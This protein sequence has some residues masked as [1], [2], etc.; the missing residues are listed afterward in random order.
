ML[1]EAEPL[2]RMVEITL[3]AQFVK[4][5]EPTNLLLI[6]KPETGKTTVLSISQKKDFVFYVNEITAKMLV[7][8]VF[9]LVER[10]EVKVVV[11]P[12]LL[13]CLE[14]Q[15]STRQQFLM[16]IKTAIE[17]GFTQ[18]QTYHKRYLAK[19]PI[20]F[21]MI[22]AITVEDFNK[23]KKYLETTGLLS[24]FI[25]FSYDYPIDKVRRILDFIENGSP[26]E[27][28]IEFRV[29]KREAE[30]EGNPELFRR[31]E[32][33]STKLG[34]EYSGFGFRAQ[35][36]LQR[37]AKAAALNRGSKKVEAQDVEEILGLSRWINYEFNPL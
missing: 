5:F 37:L 34:R 14:K 35:E 36:H 23:T 22:S 11:I 29:V 6:G 20:K 18:V 33:V 8:V 28:E 10:K 1:V 32:I 17:E 9:P 27:K 7:D 25:P 3:Q 30:V 24:R 31:L 2:R 19:E 26:G 12:D 4:P 13:N 21:S 16:L 15:K